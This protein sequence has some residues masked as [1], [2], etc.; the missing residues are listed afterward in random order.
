MAGTSSAT[1]TVTSQQETV[2]RGPD[3][4]IVNGYRVYFTT[5]SGVTGSIFVPRPRYNV[6]NVKALLAAHVAE[7]EAVSGSTGA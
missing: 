4:Q 2:D 5:P 7:L 3:G 6:A 1:W